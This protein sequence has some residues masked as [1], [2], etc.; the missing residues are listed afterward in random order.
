MND[1]D[2]AWSWGGWEGFREK[3]TFELGS[4]RSGGKSLETLNPFHRIVLNPDCGGGHWDTMG[5][6]I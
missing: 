5:T 6:Q 4:E 2:K 3:R 1:R